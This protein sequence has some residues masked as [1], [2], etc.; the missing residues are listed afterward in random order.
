MTPSRTAVKIYNFDEGLLYIVLNLAVK[1]SILP[2]V[3]SP[4]PTGRIVDEY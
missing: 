2:L 1:L 4:L 3:P